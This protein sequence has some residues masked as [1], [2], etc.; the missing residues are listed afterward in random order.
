MQHT[1]V[2]ISVNILALGMFKSSKTLST[3]YNAIC[4]QITLFN[5]RSSFHNYH[6]DT[7]ILTKG[8]AFFFSPKIYYK[9]ITRSSFLFPV[10]QFLNS[11]C[12]PHVNIVDKI[13]IN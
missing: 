11:I 10:P 2:S 13:T 3:K 1:S 5:L 8:A 12:K 7:E 6:G 9:C 4:N